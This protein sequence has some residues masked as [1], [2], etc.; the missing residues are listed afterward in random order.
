MMR[1][2]TGNH[3]NKYLPWSMVWALTLS[4]VLHT[5]LFISAR[6]EIHYE[7]PHTIINAT[8]QTTVAKR[9]DSQ[10]QRGDSGNSSLADAPT[11]QDASRAAVAATPASATQPKKTAQPS[12]APA[13]S[14]PS[15]TQASKP[16]VAANQPRAA[17]SARLSDQEP[18]QETEAPS[19][20]QSLTNAITPS[21]PAPTTVPPTEAKPVEDANIASNP[22]SAT[23]SASLKI[24]GDEDVITDPVERA[25]YKE[26]MAHLMRK[27]P[28][29]P[30]GIIGNVRLQLEINYSQV[31]TGVEI[32][33]SSGDKRTDEWARRAALSV[34]P[35]PP[36]PKSLLQPYYFRP[37]IKLAD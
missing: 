1:P 34:S 8:I 36:V 24:R 29:H 2:L 37:T 12:T 7:R 3:A 16:V 18:Q 28:A 30:P 11:A 9:N 5:A 32:I 26:L 23:N 25:Y 13:A 33:V 14:A 6:T 22:K 27:L 35:V 15:K 21:Q 17:K 31:I 19:A 20:L 10:D 4:I